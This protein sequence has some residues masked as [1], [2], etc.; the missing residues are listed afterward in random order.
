M[1]PGDF[2]LKAQEIFT[3]DF[4]K[5]VKY[6]KT[7]VLRFIFFSGL[8]PRCFHTHGGRRSGGSSR[9]PWPRLLLTPFLG[10]LDAGNLERVRA[11][12]NTQQPWKPSSPFMP[13][14]ALGPDPLLARVAFL[15]SFGDREANK[16]LDCFLVATRT[17]V[18]NE[19]GLVSTHNLSRS[20]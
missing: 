2:R 8:V 14:L 12:E 20:R 16:K 9:S 15:V 13:G 5:Q 6:A 18:W 4:P 7:I 11:G 19:L 3:P 10:S 1:E 17:L